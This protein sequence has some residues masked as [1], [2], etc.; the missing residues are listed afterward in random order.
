MNDGERHEDT[1]NEG[2]R[3]LDA[4]KGRY[5]DGGRTHTEELLVREVD[6]VAPCR[7]RPLAGGH[8]GVSVMDVGDSERKGKGAY[9]FGRVSSDLNYVR[10]Y[11]AFNALDEKKHE[12]SGYSPEESQDQR[13]TRRIYTDD[14]VYD[15]WQAAVLATTMS[16]TERMCYISYAMHVITRTA[17][18]SINGPLHHHEERAM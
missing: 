3:L 18:L 5:R 16:R 14:I 15:D 6:G 11:T 1:K 13:W 17:A 8:R 2:R 12:K 7:V 9:H 4:F 10:Q